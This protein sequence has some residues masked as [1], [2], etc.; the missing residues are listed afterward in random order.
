MFCI[1]LWLSYLC[2]ELEKVCLV[3]YLMS[4]NPGA[5]HETRVSFISNFYLNEDI[6]FSCLCIFMD[7]FICGSLSGRDHHFRLPDDWVL[8]H[9]CQPCWVSCIMLGTYVLSRRSC[10]IT[11]I[12]CF[13]LFLSK[14]DVLM[15]HAVPCSCIF[16][17]SASPEAYM[18]DKS[19]LFMWEW[20]FLFWR[21][22]N[23]I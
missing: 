11:V 23:S 13:T 3:W 22:S 8:F 19:S 7:L 10:G 9:F 6:L 1:V 20:S 16:L 21:D 5:R 2:H 18:Y 4:E 12:V 14:T 17:Y 15:S